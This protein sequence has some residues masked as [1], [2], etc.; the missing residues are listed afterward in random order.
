MLEEVGIPRLVVGGLGSGSGKT[1]ISLGLTAAL[2]ARP[3]LSRPS[4]WA[5]ISSTLPTRTRESAGPVATAW[6]RGCSAGGRACSLRTARSA[7]TASSSRVG[8]ACSTVTAWPLTPTVESTRFPGST[9]DVARIIS[10]PVVL[11]VDAWAM[12]ETAA[13]PRS[14]SSSLDSA[15]SV[16]GVPSPTTSPTTTDAASSRTRSG[17]WPGCRCSAPPTSHRCGHPRAA[18]RAAAMIQNR[19][20]DGGDHRARRRDG[21]RLRPRPRRTPDGSCASRPAGRLAVARRL[22]PRP[23]T[24]PH[25]CSR[26]TTRLCRTTPRTSS[27]SRTRRGDRHVLALE[28]IALPRDLGLDLLSEAASRRRTC[29]GSP[30]PVVPRVPSDARTLTVFLSTPRVVGSSLGANPAPSDGATH[31]MAGL[32]S[33]R[34]R[35]GGGHAAQRIS[36]PQH[37]DS[38][39]ARSEGTRLRGHEFHFSR[40]LS[41]PTASTREQSMHDQGDGEPLG[42][43]GLTIRSCSRRSSTCIS[44]RSRSL[45]AASSPQRASPR[46]RGR[47]PRCGTRQSIHR[48]GVEAF[49]A[50]AQAVSTIGQCVARSPRPAVRTE[51]RHDLIRALHP[52]GLFDGIVVRTTRDPQIENAILALRHGPVRRRGR[53]VAAHRP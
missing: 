22:K 27:C 10:A 21:E 30:R 23:R 45:P 50:D 36:R 34:H 53:P 49:D 12:G 2:R 33:D 28:D 14:A 52:R 19:H 46:T 51:L 11:V 37:C 1:S 38:I 6:I 35:A 26:S 39:D 42:F 47:R 15:G 25:R 3:H 4:R 18:H 29:R 48:P 17:R 41:G 5:P 16:I 13:A 31:E 8:W 7:R 40:V 24:G 9:L 20:V 44:A 32:T 43:E